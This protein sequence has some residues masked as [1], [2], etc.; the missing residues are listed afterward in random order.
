MPNGRASCAQVPEVDDLVPPDAQRVDLRASGDGAVAAVVAR[1]VAYDAA[2]SAIDAAEFALLASELASNAVRHGHGG[3]I[4]LWRS[5]DWLGL[6]V[7]DHG[8]GDADA[9]E[10][11]LAVAAVPGP[12]EHGLSA[13]HRLA[14]RVA[15]ANPPGGG[16]AVAAWRR[17]RYP[18]GS[19]S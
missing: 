6:L 12:A 19:R 15:F 9:L 5:A 18:S 17:C 7:I 4:W 14:D 13:V 10:R 1:Q 11:R 16:L 2:A 3:A 8:A